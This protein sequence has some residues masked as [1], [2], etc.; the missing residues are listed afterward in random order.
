M[1]SRRRRPGIAC[2]LLLAYLPA[3]TSW[4]VGTPTPAQ[5]VE[6]EHP[7]AVR[8]TRSDG[9]RMEFRTPK[10]QGD[11]LVGTAG[12]DTTRQVSLPLSDVR[13]VDVKRVSA[14]KTTLA[15][16]GGAVG[17]MIG[18]AIVATIVECSQPE[19]AIVC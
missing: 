10:V 4:E 11:S 18:V 17:V 19:N 2:L 16:V 1:I 15:V 12:E 8:V 14:W 9:T 3:C 5:F 6:A 13:S 7:K